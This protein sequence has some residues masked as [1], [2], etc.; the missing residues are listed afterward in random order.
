MQAKGRL[1]I[2]RQKAELT[3][4]QPAVMRRRPRDGQTF[5]YKATTRKTNK[6]AAAVRMPTSVPT[7]GPT[8]IITDIG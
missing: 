2:A 1:L 8:A 5:V 3:K 4:N 7:R 6:P